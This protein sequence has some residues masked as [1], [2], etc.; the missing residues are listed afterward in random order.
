MQHTGALGIGGGFD[1][2]RVGLGNRRA[3]FRQFGFN[4]IRGERRQQL[5]SAHCVPHIDFDFDQ[6]QAVSLR[7]DTG[8]LPSHDV[9]AG[10]DPVRKCRGPQPF[11]GYSQGRLSCRRCRGFLFRRVAVRRR[12]R[13]RDDDAGECDAGGNKCEFLWCFHHQ[14]RGMGL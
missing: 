5:P 13:D 3:G 11:N 9:A 4:R 1:Q 8:L 2:R 10:R 14:I 7:A 6:A 12:E